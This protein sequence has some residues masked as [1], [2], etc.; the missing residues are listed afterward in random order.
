MFN[1]KNCT[2][3]Q[4]NLDY[5]FILKNRGVYKAVDKDNYQNFFFV[6]NG[7][8]EI[9]VIIVKDK[10]VDGSNFITLNDKKSFGWDTKVFTKIG[11]ELDCTIK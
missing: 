10:L 6:S 8:N 9:V 1:I 11:S 3:V 4:P 2:L 7:E 5:N